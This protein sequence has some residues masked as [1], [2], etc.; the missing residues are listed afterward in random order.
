M[1]SSASSPRARSPETTAMISTAASIIHDH[2]AIPAAP[3][4]PPPNPGFANA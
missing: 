3:A 2:F 1:S 4:P